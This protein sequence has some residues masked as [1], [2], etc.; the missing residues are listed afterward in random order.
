MRRVLLIAVVLV[1]V[2]GCTGGGGGPSEPTGLSLPP[3]PRDLRID[4]VEPCSLLTE[5][6]RAELGLEQ[7]A[8]SFVDDSALYGGRVPSCLLRGSP[9]RPV[10]VGIG[11]VTTV[12][13]ERFTEGHLAADLETASVQ[14][15][16]AVVA[17]PRGADDYCNVEIDIAQGQIV[18]VVYGDVALAPP[19]AQSDLCREGV[20]VAEA[21]VRTLLVG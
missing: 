14:G 18:D 13:I 7:Q 21:I 10:R 16:P 17:T 9:V 3:R 6:Q 15:F 1:L 5:Q 4:G 2:G 8:N 20:R 11:V 19:I 12:G